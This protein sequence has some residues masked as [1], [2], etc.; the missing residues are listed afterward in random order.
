MHFC[1]WTNTSPVHVGK[2]EC[3]VWFIHCN[4]N[5]FSSLSQLCDRNY[6]TEITCYDPCMHVSFHCN[7]LRVCGV[8]GRSQSF[9]MRYFVLFSGISILKNL[10]EKGIHLGTND[11]AH[12]VRNWN[13]LISSLAQVSQ[14]HFTLNSCFRFWP[15]WN[16]ILCNSVRRTFELTT[17]VWR[18]TN[19]SPGLTR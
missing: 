10:C 7:W 3:K 11:P 1:S 6:L 15:F 4:A 13:I 2:L 18:K 8:S 12:K 9:L 19:Y 14:C 5:L 16:W 17:I